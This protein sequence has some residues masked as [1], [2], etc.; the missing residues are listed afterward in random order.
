[1]KIAK[2]WA[3]ILVLLRPRPSRGL[4]YMVKLDWIIWMRGRETMKFDDKNQRH[5]AFGK[6]K[7]FSGR[8]GILMRGQ[9][10]RKPVNWK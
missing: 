3:W 8:N 4:L 9:D 10:T 7:D 1:V 5:G 6:G 2:R